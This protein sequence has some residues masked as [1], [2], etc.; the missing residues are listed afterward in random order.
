MYSCVPDGPLE[1]SFIDKDW[2]CNEPRKKVNTTRAKKR[3]LKKSR[4]YGFT[5]NE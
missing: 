1:N 2:E 5:V 4:K 3:F